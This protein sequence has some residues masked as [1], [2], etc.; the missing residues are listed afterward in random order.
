[1]ST[2]AARD[3]V[4]AHAV[5]GLLPRTDVDPATLLRAWIV[6]TVRAELAAQH[7]QATPTVYVTTVEAGALARVSVS[8]IRRWA[9]EGRLAAVGAGRELRFLRTDV[10]G[11]IGQVRRRARR[12][13]ATHEERVSG[14]VR[15]I[16]LRRGQASPAGLPSGA[17]EL[18]GLTPKEDK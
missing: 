18:V 17:I 1:M 14:D 5:P 7:A 8:T 9:R 4:A 10:E 15:R 16:M 2:V 12:V 11:L 6:D 3:A 13:T